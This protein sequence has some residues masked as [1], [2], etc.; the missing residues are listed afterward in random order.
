MT[1]LVS[2]HRRLFAVWLALVAATGVSWAVGADHGDAVQAGT[3]VSLAI[4]FLKIRFVGM[5]FME[6]REAPPGLRRA[7]EGWVAVVGT[8]VVVLYLAA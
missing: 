1:A 3:A 7:F 8:T 4:A 6:L 2:E 5:D